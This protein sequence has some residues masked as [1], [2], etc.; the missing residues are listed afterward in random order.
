M[1]GVCD[2]G[3][4]REW[5]SLWAMG[6]RAKV[7]AANP[8]REL[9]DRRKRGIAANACSHGA[10]ATQLLQPVL[11]ASVHRSTTRALRSCRLRVPAANRAA[12]PCTHARLAVH[13]RPLRQ[14]DGSGT[15]R[16]IEVDV[17]RFPQH[18]AVSSTSCG[19]R[20]HIRRRHAGLSTRL[21][22]CSCLASR[23]ACV[24]VA[25]SVR[26]AGGGV[27]SSDKIAGPHYEPRAGLCVIAAP[28]AHDRV[29]VTKL[30]IATPPRPFETSTR[31][32]TTQISPPHHRP[33][34]H[35]STI[36]FC[37]LKVDQ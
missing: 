27:C 3:G 31:V 12:V 26:E 18:C 28:P 33:L 8:P 11:H 21:R 34:C 35:C 30:A 7:C 14:R 24:C 19:L 10:V 5:G 9:G 13:C 6:E 1:V 17:A 2:G 36:S 25:S 32:Y 20:S 16:T 15:S 4:V 23:G 29:K 22:A 37:V